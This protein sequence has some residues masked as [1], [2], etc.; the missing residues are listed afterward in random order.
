MD[1]TSRK[2]YGYFNDVVSF[3]ST[4][5]TNQYEYT[6][7]PFTGVNHH[8]QSVLFG[9]G[10]LLHETEESYTWLFRS[11]LRAMGAVAP[12]VIITDECVRMKN[13]IEKTLPNTAH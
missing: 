7:A 10:F 8:M 4:Y 5:N 2:N 13:A 11:F 1:A 3:D 12:R 9:A 6:F